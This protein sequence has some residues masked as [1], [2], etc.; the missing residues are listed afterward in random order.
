MLGGSCQRQQYL[1]WE[2]L[3]VGLTGLG[4]LR[5]NLKANLVTLG[6][7]SIA[8]CLT[9]PYLTRLQRDVFEDLFFEPVHGNDSGAYV[10][11]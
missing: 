2:H 9:S 5:Q 10:H 3:R 1:V 7:I 4:V 11:Q 6:W 8:F